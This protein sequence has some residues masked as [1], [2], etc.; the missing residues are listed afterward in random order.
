MSSF[1]DLLQKIN[2][3]S[4]ESIIQ[5]PTAN[6]IKQVIRQVGGK[7]RKLYVEQLD[8]KLRLKDEEFKQRAPP[9]DDLAEKLAEQQRL[10]EELGKLVVKLQGY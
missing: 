3:E 9:I 1:D 6:K 5:E 8:E 4:S 7:I 10:K 2:K